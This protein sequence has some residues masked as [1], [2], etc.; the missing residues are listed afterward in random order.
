MVSCVTAC[1]RLRVLYAGEVGGGGTL[2]SVDTL[3]SVGTLGGCGGDRGTGCGMVI[4]SSS[5]SLE[6]LSWSDT[7]GG[8]DGCVFE[9]C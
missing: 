5:L 2:G 7:A 9:F 3:G 6:L 8:G 4:D 1:M